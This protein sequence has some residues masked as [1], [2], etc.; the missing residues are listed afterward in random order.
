MEGSMAETPL[1]ENEKV[2]IIMKDYQI[3][4]TLVL[5]HENYRNRFSDVIDEDRKF[6]N[7]TNAEVTSIGDGSKKHIEFLCVSKEFIIFIYPSELEK[8]G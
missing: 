2:T 1:Q 7:I 6:L 8:K 4:G 3:E 5:R